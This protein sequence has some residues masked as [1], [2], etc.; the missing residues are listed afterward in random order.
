MARVTAP[1]ESVTAR[2]GGAAGVAVAGVG[3]G[4]DGSG[5]DQAALRD[6]LAA[7]Q[8]DLPAVQ[9]ESGTAALTPGSETALRRLAAVLTELPGAFLVQGRADPGAVPTDTPAIAAARAASV[10]AWLVANGIPGER[11]FAA[12]DGAA[13]PEQTLLTLVVMQ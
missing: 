11:M 3:R 5:K 2:A 13:A 4:A 10:K 1:V 6:E 8:A 12:G 7:G 9:F